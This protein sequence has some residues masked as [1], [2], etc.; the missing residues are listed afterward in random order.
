MGMEKIKSLVEKVKRQTEE[1]A[2]LEQLLATVQ[3][4]QKEIVGCQ[5]E[6]SVLGASRIAV[7]GP[8]VPQAIDSVEVSIVKEEK[9]YFELNVDAD[10]F[11]EEELPPA[12]IPTYEEVEQLMKHSQQ[13]AK[14]SAVINIVADPTMEEL[15]TLARQPKPPTRV[16]KQAPRSGKSSIKDLRK[17]I[18][19]QD[20][21]RY[22]KE[23]FRG[24][25]STF[26][27]SIQT[28]NRFNTYNEADYWITRELRT[29]NGWLSSNPTV[30]EFEQLVR[31]RFS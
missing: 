5:K 9:E 26:D 24:D 29:K 18:N 17:A 3:M 7:M 4:L 1:G 15:P 30:Q 12:G 31:R 11:S 22:I 28:I 13:G 20:R 25:E 19:A 27:R 10:V 6:I 8:A 23:L 2:P 14:G 21:L 16:A